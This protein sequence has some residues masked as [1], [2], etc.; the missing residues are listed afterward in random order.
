[1]RI[2]IAAALFVTSFQAITQVAIE[3]V[4]RGAV[5]IFAA[6][7]FDVAL[8]A[9]VSTEIRRRLEAGQYATLQTNQELADRL[10]RDLLELTR[11]KHVA[12]GLR[13]AGTGSNNSAPRRDVPTAAGFRRTD[14]LP[15]NIGL[16]D[17]AFFMRPVEHRDALEAAMRTLHSADALIL[18]L[19]DN[20]GGS[21][22]TVALLISYLLDEPGRP[23][24]EIRPRTGTADVYVTESVSP[25]LRNGQRAVYVLT[26]RRTFSGGEGLAFL[27]QDMKRALVIGEITAGAAN[28]G[29]G[30]PINEIFEIHVSNGQLLTARS[31]RNWEGAGVVPDVPVAAADALRVAHLRAIDDL[32]MRMPLGPQ[33]E[34]LARVRTL[35]K[36]A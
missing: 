5:D 23:L 1:M 34:E 10:T 8:S 20:G 30:Y 18:D 29:R 9:S 21:P 36:G 4:V 17:I 15:G 27:L 28:P 16:L 19:R 26:S 33:R 24:F 7:Y 25:E 12:V 2:L 35:I 13:R 32:L 22:G 3:P 6:Q 11:D 31:Q 14:I